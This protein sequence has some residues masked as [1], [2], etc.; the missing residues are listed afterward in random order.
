M[1]LSPSIQQRTGFTLAEL[2][3]AVTILSI[4]LAISIPQFSSFI[5]KMQLRA[6]ARDLYSNMQSTRLNAV[7]NNRTWAIVFDPP[8]NRYIICSDKGADGA[9]SSTTDN[10]CP[11]TIDLTSLYKN[12]IRYGHGDLTGNKSATKPPGAFPVNDVSFNSNVLSFNPLGTSGAGYVYLQN[13]GKTPLYA[14]GT[15]SSGSIQ[16]LRWTG[17][18][19]KK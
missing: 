11:T 13:Q 6:A 4:L 1:S 15:Q 10:T 5:P 16:I 18:A 7:K 17:T 14:I 8:N 2:L 19:W 9:W 12:G 3:I